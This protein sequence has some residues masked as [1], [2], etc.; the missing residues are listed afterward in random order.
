[1]LQ[2][3]ELPRKVEQ[4][5]GSC[6][7]AGEQETRAS[8]I[9]VVLWRCTQKPHEHNMSGIQPRPSEIYSKVGTKREWECLQKV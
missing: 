3:N 9:S 6:Y 2:G 1:M 4:R 8:V 7:T 5:K